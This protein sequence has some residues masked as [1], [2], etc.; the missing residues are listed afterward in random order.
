[1]VAAAEDV[2]RLKHKLFEEKGELQF[3]YSLSEP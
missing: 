2:Q 1:M 3:I